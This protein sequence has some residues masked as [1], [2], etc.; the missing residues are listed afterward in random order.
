MS[1]E[2]FVEAFGSKVPAS[3]ENALPVVTFSHEVSFHVNGDEI[4]VF[5]VP[6]A[7]TDGDAVI[8]LRKANVVHMGDLFFNGS[9]PFIDLSSGGSVDG[10]IAAADRVME[11]ITDDTKV[12]PGHGAIGDRKA[13]KA[14]RDMLITVR[15]NVKA[16]V[17]A[18]KTLD[19]VIDAGPS[20]KFDE[21]WGEGF[22]KPADFI[23]IV[24]SSLKK[25][26]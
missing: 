9:Y 8:Y 10:V 17:Q 18:G 12:M 19:Q 20:K 11:L 13:L 15:D 1:T 14:F 26:G 7:H 5:H 6:S 25:S 23:K 21:K 22:M 3:P 2:Q 4:H 24:Y 16:M